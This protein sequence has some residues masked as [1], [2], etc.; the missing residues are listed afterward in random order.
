M[1]LPRTQRKT[2]AGND[3]GD[4]NQFEK[5]GLMFEKGLLCQIK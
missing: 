4:T 5:C 1:Y 3:R 2:T